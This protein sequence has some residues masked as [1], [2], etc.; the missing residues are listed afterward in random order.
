MEKNEA[1]YIKLEKEE[2]KLNAKKEDIKQ[3]LAEIQEEKNKIQ[4]DHVNVILKEENIGFFDLINIL[5][6]K[7]KKDERT[8]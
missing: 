6:N 1:R 7:E 8:V 3:K 4:A 5:K 2:R